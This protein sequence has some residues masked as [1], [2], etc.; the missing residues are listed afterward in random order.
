MNGTIEV[1]DVLKRLESEDEATR[2]AAQKELDEVIK[3]KLD[4]IKDEALK[5]KILIKE[6][7]LY[8]GRIEGI[9]DE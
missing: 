9:R 4:E 7:K 6:T 5:E 3:P 8:K 2:Q 1:A